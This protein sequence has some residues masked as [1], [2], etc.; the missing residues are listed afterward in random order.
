MFV[1]DPE[2]RLVTLHRGDTGVVLYRL[3][4]YNMLMPEDRV[5]L[6]MRD[7]FG[8]IIRE[9]I[10]EIDVEDN[11]FRVVF[12]NEDTE[13]LAPGRYR[14][15]VRVVIGPEYDDHGK[16]EDGEAISTPISPLFL[17]VLDT[18]GRFQEEA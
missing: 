15:D 8:Q 3:V 14:Y 7:A 4:G 9:E 1:I 16:I 6:V 18:V 13:S 5:K 17:Q 12:T 11:T 2:E 10:L